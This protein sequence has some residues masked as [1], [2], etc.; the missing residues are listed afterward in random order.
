MDV[1]AKD[2]HLSWWQEREFQ[3][4]ELKAE[5][6]FIPLHSQAGLSRRKP[7][8]CFPSMAKSLVKVMGKEEEGFPPILCPYSK[9]LPSLLGIHI[10]SANSTVATA[11][12]T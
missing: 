9:L 8:S 12:R 7:T 4:C 1:L 11:S 2:E 3:G 6:C 10:Q 5:L